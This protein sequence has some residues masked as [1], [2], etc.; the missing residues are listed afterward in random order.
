M[1]R[2]VFQSLLTFFF[3][4]ALSTKPSR[5]TFAYVKHGR[6]GFIYGN[7]GHLL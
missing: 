5:H 3:A 6:Q 4:A 7:L 1:C 2:Q